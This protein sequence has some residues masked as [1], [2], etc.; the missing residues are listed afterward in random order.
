MTAYSHTCAVCDLQLK[1]IDASHIVPVSEDY[2]TDEMK[3]GIALCALHHRAYDKSLITFNERYQVIH[4]QERMQNLREIKHDS[5]LE[6]FIGDLKPIINLP[7]AK[8]DRPPIDYIKR[9]N[10]IRGWK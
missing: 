9:A 4:N 5:G 3:N 6:K 10:Q 8:N 1:L 2:S 7:P